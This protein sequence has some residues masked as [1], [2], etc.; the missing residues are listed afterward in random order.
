MAHALQVQPP[1]VNTRDAP[2]SIQRMCGILEGDAALP[3]KSTDGL[4]SQNSMSIGL[5]V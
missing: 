5:W 3:Q 4:V 2:G 1:A